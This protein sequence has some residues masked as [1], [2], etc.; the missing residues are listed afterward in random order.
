M[1]R[2]ILVS[3]VLVGFRTAAVPQ[4]KLVDLGTLGGKSGSE[5]FGVNN[6]GAVVGSTAVVLE[7]SA[8][9]FAQP[10]LADWGLEQAFVWKD[11]R[12][13][14]LKPPRYN[15]SKA[16]AINDQGLVIGTSQA[17]MISWWWKDGKTGDLALQPD[18]TL[19]PYY[20]WAKRLNN[21]GQVV[22]AARIW[23]NGVTRA[24]VPGDDQNELKPASVASAINDAGVVVGSRNINDVVSA[25]VVERGVVRELV[26]L[27]GRSVANDINNAGVVVGE[28]SKDNAPGQPVAWRNGLIEMLPLPTGKSSGS[29]T[30]INRTGDIVGSSPGGFDQPRSA[31]LWHNGVV[32]DLNS[33]LPKGT[34]WTLVD[35]NDINDRGW[36]VGKGTK[37]GESTWRAYL[38][39]PI[40][41]QIAKPLPAARRK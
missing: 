38:L 33:V 15:S 20:L 27:G 3:I 29:A 11:G 1:K 39:M 41:E 16:L 26:G 30:A 34:E 9:P 25:I 35:A 4:Y 14:L 18:N 7:Q 28:S 31:M 40:S 24:L 32:T 17:G 22:G 2:L 12:F 21:K 13:T 23:E 8:E 10:K 5:A 36:I 6:R 19:S 37:E